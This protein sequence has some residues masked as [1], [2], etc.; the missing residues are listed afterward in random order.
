MVM[1]ET[2]VY[3]DKCQLV[4]FQIETCSL[5][6]LNLM[7]IFYIFALDDS[8]NGLLVIRREKNNWLTKSSLLD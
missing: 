5:Y 3:D 7:F 8:G 2:F 1:S 6:V 4:N